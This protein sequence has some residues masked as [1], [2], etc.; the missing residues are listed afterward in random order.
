MK[1]R[2]R[3]YLLIAS[4]LVLWGLISVSCA[5]TPLEIG[6]ASA[7]AGAATTMYL[8]DDPDIIIDGEAVTLQG[9]ESNAFSLMEV[10]IENIWALA[11]LAMLF[12]FLP[13]PSEIRKRFKKPS[14]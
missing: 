14:K 12:W 6:L 3:L 10:V 13:S 11:L 9:A 5:L 4:S 1:K 7:A 2:E 8:D